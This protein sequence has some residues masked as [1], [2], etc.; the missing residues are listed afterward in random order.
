MAERLSHRWQ[1]AA[2]KYRI[3]LIQK[4]EEDG[5][6]LCNLA[7][8]TKNTKNRT[9]A[10]VEAY[11]WVVVYNGVI[12]SIGDAGENVRRTNYSGSGHVG[13]E[14]TWWKDGGGDDWWRDFEDAIGK[15]IRSVAPKASYTVGKFDLYVLNAAYYTSWLEDGSYAV[16]LA[17]IF[18]H[19][20]DIKHWHVISQIK[21]ECERTAA[22]YGRNSKVTKVGIHGEP[23][24]PASTSSY[25]Y[26][27]DWQEGEF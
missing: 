23:M 18:G 4:L 14:G 2:N 27:Y 6:R 25:S 17:K 1:V 20:I 13:L 22:K 12:K 7:A 15:L 16:G 26:H 3:R 19:P 21:S 24:K 8:R 9:G 10:Q 11:F 5:R